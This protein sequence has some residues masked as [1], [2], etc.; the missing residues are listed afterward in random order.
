MAET[1]QPKMR[2]PRELNTETLGPKWSMW[3]FE[4]GHLTRLTAYCTT[5][6]M[7]YMW[8]VAHTAS[9]T[10]RWAR[11][12]VRCLVWVVAGWVSRLH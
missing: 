1:T 10:R 9:L 3:T 6:Y 4:P 2:L 7:T 5:I 11:Q 8:L 12:I